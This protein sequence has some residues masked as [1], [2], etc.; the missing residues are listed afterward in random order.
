MA[1]G[2]VTTAAAWLKEVYTPVRVLQVMYQNNPA[3]ALIPKDE[4]FT[5]ADLKQP[6]IYA[7]P[8]GQATDFATAQAVAQ[9]SASVPFTIKRKFMYGYATVSR[10]LMKAT[11]DDKG[12]FLR[13]T[14]PEFEGCI[15]RVKRA[16]ALYMYRTGTGSLATIGSVVNS[17]G[18][19][20]IT[21]ANSRDA[22]N[23]EQNDSLQFSTTDGGGTTRTQTSNRITKV[24]RALGKLTL[25][26]A[27]DA[28]WSNNPLTA[29]DYIYYAGAALNVAVNGFQ[30]WLPGSDVTATPFLGV[31]RTPDPVRLAGVA[32]TNQDYSG[33]SIEEALM[34]LATDIADLG[35][36]DPDYCF[37]TPVAFNNLAKELG[38][39]VR[40]TE[41]VT[42][43]EGV[44][45]SFKGIAL[46]GPRGSEIK[47]IA[48][49]NV[50]T[51]RA[52]MVEL[53]TWKLHSLGPM[54]EWVDDD[55]MSFLRL[56]TS[57]SFEARFAGYGEIGCDAP[58]H[59]GQAKISA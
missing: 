9:G 31:D 32:G 54:P 6:V 16:L 36:G 21:L 37:I 52:F 28:G 58:G 8:A 3:L 38:S 50:P 7:N 42:E 20:V 22:K 27:Y 13:Y 24:D 57:D 11:K 41:A 23:F 17:G 45:F 19:A 59:N 44:K 4:S 47:I 25:N 53:E 14:R 40:Y 26:V 55:G 2:T 43:R 39:K 56:A 15:N 35:D 48:D 29:G 5:G 30:A 46:N 18:V 12:A 33:L 10:E 34:N 49:Y 1:D 51:G